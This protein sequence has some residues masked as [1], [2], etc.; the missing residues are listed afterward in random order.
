MSEIS[1]DYTSRFR[2]FFCTAHNFV[3]VLCHLVQP[4]RPLPPPSPSASPRF[5]FSGCGA[6]WLEVTDRRPVAFT[7]LPPSIPLH[8][9]TA[10]A[11]L[12]PF[13]RSRSSRSTPSTRISEH[14]MPRV[15]SIA[16]PVLMNLERSADLEH[17]QV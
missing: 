12:L 1:R 14:S 3:P 4:P 16:P 11:G 7:N 6:I 15:D 8:P 5:I 2:A 13:S 17:S 9:R 10:T